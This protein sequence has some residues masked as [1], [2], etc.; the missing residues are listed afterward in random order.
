MVESLKAPKW[1]GQSLL[2]SI[3]FFGHDY[4]ITFPKEKYIVDITYASLIGRM[5]FRF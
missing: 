4:I 5:V 1:Q 2:V 3:K